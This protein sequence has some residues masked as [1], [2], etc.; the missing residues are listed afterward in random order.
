MSE[1]PTQMDAGPN[2]TVNA[3]DD[4]DQELLEQ[5]TK[6]GNAIDAHWSEWEEEARECF[7][8]VAG[9]QWASDVLDA[10][11]D[12]GRVPVTFNR[13][14]PTIDAVSGAEIMGRQQ[15]IYEP[16][17]VGAS[18]QNEVLTKGADWVRDEC[19]AEHEDSEASRDCLICGEGWTEMR[20]DYDDEP[21][22]QIVIE[23]I[24]PLQIRPDPS[25]KKANFRDRR[26][27]RRRV[28]YTI[29]DFEAMWPDASPEGD[30]GST[31]APTIV[32]PKRRYKGDDGD[33]ESGEALAEG[34][35]MVEAWQWYETKVVHRV[36]G[37]TG[38]E[39]FLDP[40]E[41]EQ[42]KAMA[43]DKGVAIRS[44]RQ[45]ARRYRQAWVASG[46]I[47]EVSDIDIGKF[48]WEAMTGKRDRN[49]RCW[50]GLVRPM[51]DPQRFANKFFT[52]IMNILDKNA[53]GGLLIEDG[54]VDDIRQFEDSYADPGQNTYVPRGTL[55]EG[56]IKDKTPPQYP[57]GQD[58]LMTLSVEGIRDVTGV[59]EEMLGL[60]SRDQPGVL[61]H[62]RKQAAYGIL[63]AFFDAFRRYRKAQGRLLLLFMQKFLP[64]DFLIRIVGPDGSPAYQAIGDAFK[65]TRFSV[66]VDDTPAG[67]N[68]KAQT[69]QML[70]QLMP[71]LQQAELGPEFWAEIVPYSPLPTGLSSKLVKMLMGLASAPPSPQDQV[72]LAGAQAKVAKDQGQAMH[73][74]AQANRLNSEAGT[75]AGAQDAAAK[76]DLAQAAK[77]ISDTMHENAP[78]PAPLTIE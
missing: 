38:Q 59:N 4:D 68:E 49:K 69:W 9:H 12:D 78:E 62:Q 5:F 21:D 26:Y 52:Q 33:D 61:E 24:D 75:A 32:D 47:L 51:M 41:L 19:D 31:R 57:Q 44:V 56:K 77:Y 66:I 74:V 60:A 73:H 63:S 58:R 6:W 42:A 72:A 25:S 40:D 37:P 65:N 27:M 16:R 43:A 22:G 15:V 70:V 45:T 3:P 53:K 55:S 67:P 23:R 36:V 30:P 13:V 28:P 20:M 50:Y 2:A 14:A 39:Q 1:S 46:Q 17:Q 64:P 48:T 34:E 7:G 10:L 8:F 35:V 11:K 18:A 76:K 54:A 29:E 71:L